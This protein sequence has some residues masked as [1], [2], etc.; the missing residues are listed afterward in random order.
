MPIYTHFVFYDRT[1][2][3]FLQVV[4]LQ[5]RLNKNLIKSKETVKIKLV[6]TKTSLDWT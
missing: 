6:Q 3:R 5:T 4:Y 2:Y 1:K